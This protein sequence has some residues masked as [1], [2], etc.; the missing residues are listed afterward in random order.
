MWVE[1]DM[2]HGWVNDMLHGWVGECDM[3]HKQEVLIMWVECDMLHGC[4]T[5]HSTQPAL[6]DAACLTGQTADLQ[7]VSSTVPQLQVPRLFGR[8]MEE[9]LAFEALT[10]EQRYVELRGGPGEGKTSLACLLAKRLC[11]QWEQQPQLGRGGST[12]HAHSI[13]LRGECEHHH[14]RQ[15]RHLVPLVAAVLLNHCS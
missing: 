5:L 9:R 2:L 6:H 12:A 1:C 13:D 8:E 3:L 15:G 10:G 11:A 4:R 7:E 14:D